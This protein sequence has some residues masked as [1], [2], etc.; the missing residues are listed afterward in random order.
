MPNPE[1]FLII[2]LLGAAYRLR[3]SGILGTLGGR[4]A[5]TAAVLIAA[6]LLAFSWTDACI[7]AAGAF[8][9]MMISHSKVYQIAEP[10]KDAGPWFSICFA[11]GALIMTTHCN[12]FALL[13]F[14]AGCL[15]ANF[16]SR[17]AQQA[18]YINDMLRIA[19]PLQGLLFGA[20]LITIKG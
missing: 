11:R 2:P 13:I 9:G 14:S 19:E 15:C 8:A 20:L 17:K 16:L 12:F 6:K 1:G 7:M 10:A 4:L 5:W 3:G 18:G